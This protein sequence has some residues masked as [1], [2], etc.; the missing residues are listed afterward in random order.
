[1]HISLA[2]EL[3]INCDT[4]IEEIADAYFFSCTEPKTG[5]GEQCTDKYEKLTPQ[6]VDLEDS[7]NVVLKLD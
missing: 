6:L 3:K 2:T 4:H 7:L 1:M 5:F